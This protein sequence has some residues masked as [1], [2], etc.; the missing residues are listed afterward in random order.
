MYIVEV[1]HHDKAY[2]NGDLEDKLELVNVE[3][4]NTRKSAKNYI[5][6]CLKNGGTVHRHYHK[7]ATS[8]CYRFT[9]VTW[10]HENSGEIMHEYY[11]FTLKKIEGK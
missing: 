8:I 5:E 2:R 7:G 4:F 3:H 6:G 10:Q 1:R 11:E 9:G